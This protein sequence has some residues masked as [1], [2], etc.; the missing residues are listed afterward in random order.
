MCAKWDP[1]PLEAV[2]GDDKSPLSEYNGLCSV[3]YAVEYD[4]LTTRT[5][6][7]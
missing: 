1:A 7:R 3:T 5:G 4:L 2:M 6:T